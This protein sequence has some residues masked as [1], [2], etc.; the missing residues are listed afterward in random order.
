[1]L[2]VLQLAAGKGSRFKEHTNVDKPFILVDNMP[3]FQRSLSSLNLTNA[4]Q[5]ILF[6]K[7]HIEKYNP[8]QYVPHAHIY[9]ID[10]YTDGAASSAY[11]VINNSK[12]KNESW[13]IVDCDV[14]IKWD[15]QLDYYNHYIFVQKHQWDT[16]SSYSYVDDNNNIKC[17]AEKQP[18]SQY[19]NTGYYM[20]RSGTDMCICYEFY[21]NNNIKILNEFYM[22]P[23]YNYAIAC[24]QKV[25]AKHIDIFFT[26]GTPKDL[27]FYN[28]NKHN[29]F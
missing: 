8:Q 14:I 19:R 15:G 10:Y 7:S 24:G 25:V 16:N 23:L 17:I 26:V 6:Q 4:R 2:N 3:M 5:H 20:W 11:Y 12:F 28:A 13:L 22:S 1:M 21:K 29:Y 18:I 27:D 9:D